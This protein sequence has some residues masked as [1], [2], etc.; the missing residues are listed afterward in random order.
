MLQIDIIDAELWYHCKFRLYFK[1]M[2]CLVIE[3][4]HFHTNLPLFK[5]CLTLPIELCGNRNIIAFIQLFKSCYDIISHSACFSHLLCKYSFSQLFKSC[6]DLFVIQH[7]LVID[8]AICLLYEILLFTVYSELCFHY[9]LCHKLFTVNYVFI[10]DYAINCHT[11]V[12][13]RYSWQLILFL[14]K[15]IV[16]LNSSHLES[17]CVEA[18]FSMFMPE[19]I[20]LCHTLLWDSC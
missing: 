9:W 13:T 20:W 14:I 6:Y 17:S 5:P 12:H 16:L 1:L 18:S 7:V 15:S 2:L 4:I 3:L 11:F 10:I 19:N 8:Y